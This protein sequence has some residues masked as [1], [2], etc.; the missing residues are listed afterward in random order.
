MLRVS[1]HTAAFEMYLLF[2]DVDMRV[3]NWSSLIMLLDYV[4]L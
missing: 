3:D 2:V 4:V 1:S